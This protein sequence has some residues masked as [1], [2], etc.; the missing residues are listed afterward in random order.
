MIAMTTKA[1]KLAAALLGLM[2]WSAAHAGTVTYVYTDPQGTPLAE[3]DANGNIT[4]RFEYTPYGVSVPSMGAAPNG[5]GYTGHV[6]DSDTG[7]VYMQARYYDAEVGRFLSVDPVGPSPG[8]GF[9]FNRYAYVNNNPLLRID[10]TGKSGQ[11]FWT[12][13]NRVTYTVPYIVG[14][15]NGARMPMTTAQINEA[16]SRTF[17]GTANVNGTTVTIT[18]QAIEANG[19]NTSGRTNFINVVPDTQGITRS[20]R[21]ETNHVGGDRITIGATG[22]QRATP[23]T[24]AHELGG[25]AG[26]A[27]DQ[28]ATGVDAKGNTLEQDAPGASG[29]M[30]ALNDGPANQQTLNEI[31]NAP[32]NTNTCSPGV[33]AANGGC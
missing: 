8:D 1:M 18:A 29:I 16:I 19:S 3:A 21:S 14:L 4:A 20:G 17:S 11:L 26:G 15:S 5:V 30:K 32:T 23:N 27:G 31:I 9:T 24:V 12:A 13:P 22:A 6:N 7:L 2:L 28:Y 33:Q 10:P 25:H